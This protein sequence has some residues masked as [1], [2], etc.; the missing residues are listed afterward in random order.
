[1]PLFPSVAPTGDD[2]LDNMLETKDA[3][4]K[5][6]AKLATRRP[7][8]RPRTRPRPGERVERPKPRSIVPMMWN[9][10]AYQ[11]PIA[12]SEEEETKES[13]TV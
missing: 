3:P 8:G 7:R 12:K 13:C 6:K 1:M 9:F 11:Q 2:Q 10:A 4:T 5:K